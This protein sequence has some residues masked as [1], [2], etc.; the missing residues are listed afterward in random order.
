MF[1][2]RISGIMIV[3]ISTRNAKEIWTMANKTNKFS[4]SAV[5]SACDRFAAMRDKKYE[6]GVRN[7]RK[8]KLW[9]N[10]TVVIQLYNIALFM[11]LLI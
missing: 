4:D 9:H 6:F 5:L 11:V 1:E 3:H 7:G 8:D 10:D 2:R